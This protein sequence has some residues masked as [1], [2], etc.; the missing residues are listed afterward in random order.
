MRPR[1][2]VHACVG[3]SL[4]P[5]IQVLSDGGLV[6]EVLAVEAVTLDVLD[7]GLHLALALRVIALAG[8]DAVPD[9]SRILVEALVQRQLTVLLVEDPHLCLIVDALLFDRAEVMD[10][11]DVKLELVT[12]SGRETLVQ[13]LYYIV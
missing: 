11:M 2:A 7:P 1:R 3:D 12:P 8:M 13:H 4:E 6:L 5:I 9:G 10:G